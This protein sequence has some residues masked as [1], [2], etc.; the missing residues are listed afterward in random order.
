[1]SSGDRVLDARTV[2]LFQD[3]LIGMNPEEKLFDL[4]HTRLDERGLFVNEGKIIDASFVEVP[5]QRNRQ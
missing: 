1:L 3:N 5:R 2:R 4:F